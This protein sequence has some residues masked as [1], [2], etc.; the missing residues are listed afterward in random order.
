MN[1]SCGDVTEPFELD[2]EAFETNMYH[3]VCATYDM[4]EKTRCLVD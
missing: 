3:S 2:T 4:S 1:L